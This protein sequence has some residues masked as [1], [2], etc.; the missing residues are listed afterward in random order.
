MDAGWAR[1]IASAM[2]L[3]AG[4][5]QDILIGVISG[6]GSGGSGTT[7]TSDVGPTLDSSTTAVDP[8]T[9]DG[10]GT[11]TGTTD[12]DTS[13]STGA[14]L[15]VACEAPPEHI[16][17][18]VET[19]IIADPDV[20]SHAIGL[21]C[22][23]DP[24]QSIPISNQQYASPEANAFRVL[25]A[26]GNDAF[27]AI[28]GEHLL[29]LTTGQFLSADMDGVLQ[30]PVGET[31]SP[32][33][34]NGNPDDADLPAPISA[35]SGSAG[36][37]GGFPYLDCD[38][39]GDCSESLPTLYGNGGPAHDLIW[40]SFDIEVPP[41][42]R[43]YQIDMAWFTA[44]YPARADIDGTD[45][46]VWWQSSEAYTGNV[47][48]VDGNALSASTLAPWL[49]AQGLLG[50]LDAIMLEGTGYEAATMVPCEHPGGMYPMCPRG[51]GTGW[52]TMTGP[53]MPKETMTMAVALFDLFDMTRDST[54]L[55]D[56]WRWY[57]EGCEPGVDC[58]LAP[59]G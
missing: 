10:G 49:D 48:T 35:E 12:D 37:F 52:M 23:D 31:D 9:A 21:G 42:T 46:A 2:L 4:C 28:E 1:L 3:G 14:D 40:M 26:Y 25:T 58:G 11:S 17:C 43:G 44:E 15:P 29:A 27:S 24:R 36:G 45:I 30:V 38:G 20:M 7:S 22:D 57:C 54:L 19:T 56:N 16:P 32:G 18:D 50:G 5:G 51:A 6:T 59:K 41:G 39:V 53:A 33:Q 47:A 8:G 34:N 55:L 13:S